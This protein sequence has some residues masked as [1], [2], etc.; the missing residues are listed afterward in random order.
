MENV[1]IQHFE[2]SIHNKKYSSE[3]QGT[4]CCLNLI[5]FFK[6]DSPDRQNRTCIQIRHVHNAGKAPRRGDFDIEGLYYT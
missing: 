1:S 3:G 6:K 4:Q 2:Y 5:F